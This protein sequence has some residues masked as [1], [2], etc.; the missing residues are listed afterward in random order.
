MM[1]TLMCRSQLIP[2]QFH[3]WLTKMTTKDFW[4]LADGPWKNLLYQLA[5][6]N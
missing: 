4:G 1:Y 6:A 5:D 3:M 2:G